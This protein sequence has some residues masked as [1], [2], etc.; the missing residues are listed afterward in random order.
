MSGAS[1]ALPPDRNVSRIR[2]A[3][4]LRR[5]EVVAITRITPH[6]VRITLGGDQLAGFVSRGFDDHVK[7]FIPAKGQSFDEVPALGPNGPIFNEDGPKPEMRDYTPHDYDPDKGTVQLDFVVHD[8]GPA[9]SWALGARPGDRLI[10]GGPRGSF[11]VGS[12]FDWHLLIGDDTA[13]PAI[14]RRLAELPAGARV[15]VFAEVDG[16]EDQVPFKTAADAE[17]HWV[18]RTQARLL[19]VVAAAALPRG[20]C[21]A[22]IAC[23]SA[24]AKALRSTLLER[25]FDRATLKASGYWRRG[26]T[27]VHDVHD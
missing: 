8:A 17:I 24:E 15:V 11:V 9:T 3:L 18:H 6:L 23:E 10:I 26:V 19:D 27:A 25:G 5:L 4:R 1:F 13:L 2:H 7:L 22:W 16:P 20:S 14:R 21:Y 12:G